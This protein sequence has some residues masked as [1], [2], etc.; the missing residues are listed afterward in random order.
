[1]FNP[2]VI[3]SGS[4]PGQLTSFM[5]TLR[6]SACVSLLREEEEEESE[7]EAEAEKVDQKQRQG[8][9]Q[10]QEVGHVSLSAQ[11]SGGKDGEDVHNL[12]TTEYSGET[13]EVLARARVETAGEVAGK[14][15]PRSSP[16]MLTPVPSTPLANPQNTFLSPVASISVLSSGHTPTPTS[17]PQ[18]PNSPEIPIQ[19]THDASSTET[20]SGPK[21]TSPPAPPTQLAHLQ[22]RNDRSGSTLFPSPTAPTLPQL[23]PEMH[24]PSFHDSPSDEELFGYMEDGLSSPHKIWGG[25]GDDGGGDASKDGGCVKGV[26]AHGIMD[27]DDSPP[28]RAGA[29]LAGHGGEISKGAG[30]TDQ[31]D[32]LT[33]G[34][35][36]TGDVVPVPTD[37]GT[38][39]G[40]DDIS[41]SPV[42]DSDEEEL[43][44]SKLI[45]EA[46]AS[47]PGLDAGGVVVG[48]GSGR[49]SGERE[50]GSVGAAGAVTGP[51]ERE[52]SPE[53]PLPRSSL[54]KLYE[55]DSAPEV[56]PPPSRILE[57][58]EIGTVIQSESDLSPEASF[59]RS[60]IPELDCL[61][62]RSRPLS[63]SR[64][65]ILEHAEIGTGA[66]R[67]R[68][69]SREYTGTGK[70]KQKQKDQGSSKKKVL[71]EGVDGPVF[72]SDSD[73][74]LDLPDRA[75][76]PAPTPRT[77]PH[78]ITQA[79]DITIPESNRG[80]LSQNFGASTASV[81][82]P[83]PNTHPKPKS[84]YQ[85]SLFHFFGAS[86]ASNPTP[87]PS[88]HPKPKSKSLSKPPWS[89]IYVP[90][91]SLSPI[92]TLSSSSMEEDQAAVGNSDDSDVLI[93]PIKRKKYTKTGV[94]GEEGGVKPP[95]SPVIVVAKRK[96]N[97]KLNGELGS[98]GGAEE[99]GSAPP[100][101][102]AP[103]LKKKL[104]QLKN[105]P[106]GRSIA[107]TKVKK[108]KI[109]TMDKV[110][111]KDAE[112]KMKQQPASVSASAQ[113]MAATRV[114][115]RKAN[116]REMMMEP[117]LK[118]VKFLSA[119]AKE[120]GAES[121]SKGKGKE[122]EQALSPKKGRPSKAKGI[123]WP[124]KM[125]VGEGRRKVSCFHKS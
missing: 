71:Y 44:V 54:S 28:T 34:G 91:R 16:S 30:V 53:I 124:P 99:S 45:T 66:Q 56:S 33:A 110:E 96:L 116:E 21:P 14:H 15:D 11:P 108:R 17:H 72:D 85:G 88:T 101:L 125:K 123:K 58:T 42:P 49:G 35:T 98:K 75:R 24:V 25:V 6:R 64:S 31:D 93:L 1:M 111:E 61:R 27:E 94:D 122:K 86:T 73:R 19:P 74:D 109:Y 7:A 118:R 10:A 55:P 70:Q 105:A 8:Q 20:H 114:K 115:K 22:N 81:P 103:M 69:L 106:D 120:S 50:Q 119:R 13:E 47:S 92:S 89:P 4:Q 80:L 113:S 48:R 76:S 2:S 38:G 3:P 63:R 65:R 112:T 67:E 26:G 117:P 29:V 36:V 95:T 39:S 79:P 9:E 97:P 68:K 43:S 12:G 84:K 62:P 60:S 78:P 40:L 41:Y 59:L 46:F 82:I 104:L 18:S 77:R 90:S 107:A 57:Y 83:I 52:R 100:A 23:S 37:M 51:H 102:D 121:S 5:E 87:T 32:P